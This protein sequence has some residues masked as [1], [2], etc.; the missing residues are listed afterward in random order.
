MAI[1]SLI[2]AGLI[3]PILAAEGESLPF[4][5]AIETQVQE[6]L[7]WSLPVRAEL[8]VGKPDALAEGMS[9]GDA[10]VVS[11]D[12]VRVTLG[13]R[14]TG[15]DTPA[16]QYLEPSFVIDYEEP[17]FKALMDELREAHGK[18]PSIEDLTTFVNQAI[19]KKSSARGWDIAS[20]VARVREGDCTEHAVLLSALARASGYPARVMIGATIIVIDGNAL[21]FGHAWTEIHDGK[22]WVLA[23]ATQIEGVDR[24][25]YIRASSLTNEGIGFGLAMLTTLSD[26]GVSRVVLSNPH[27]E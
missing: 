2:L 11:D 12:L 23:D 27:E 19:E 26:V 6:D 10:V 5:A 18:A 4:L 3:V 7:D 9:G 1:S 25:Y 22:R 14:P 16:A 17:S 24:I 21:T 13:G 20:R 15:S 8:R